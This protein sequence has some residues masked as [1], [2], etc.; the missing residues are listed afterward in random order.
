MTKYPIILVHGIAIRETKLLKAFGKIES[1]LTE[2]G[3]EA[4]TAGIDA[5]GSIESNAEQLKEII[6]KILS[7]TGAQRANIIAHSKGGLDSKYMIS[8]LGMSDRIASL[9]TMCTP[10]RGSS[11][12]T[13]IWKLPMWMKKSLAF[14]INGFY[15]IMGD[16]HPDSLKVCEQLKS[17][18]GAPDEDLSLGSVY[19]QS[20]STRLMSGKDCI[21]MAVP[22][23]ICHQSNETEND[24]VV[25]A[26]SA[27]FEHYRGDCLD[28]SIS[29]TQIVDILARRKSRKR[30]L[31]FYVGLCEELAEMGY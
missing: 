29:H 15:R 19:C 23:M 26:E 21:L 28:E 7:D 18:E 27:K 4:Y 12:A 22:M 25:S 8:H 1:S 14:F 5:F 2:A 3:Y 10:H 24:G 16:K 31:T 17:A 6:L 13:W 9:T 11:V 20:F 30:I